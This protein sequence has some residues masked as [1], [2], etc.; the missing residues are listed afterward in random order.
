MTLQ[1]QTISARFAN[2]MLANVV[3]KPEFDSSWIIQA[4]LSPDLLRLE[5]TRITMERFAQ[6]YRLIAIKTDDETVGMFSRPLRNGTLKYLCM[7]MLDAPQLRVALNRFR[8]FF[9]LVN[10][11]VQFEITPA[12]EGLVRIALHE[13][14]NLGPTRVLALELMLMLMQGVTSW[15]IAR[16]IPFVRIGFTFPRPAHAAEYEHLYPGPVHFNEAVTALYMDPVYLDEPIRQDQA[17]LGVFI[18]NAPMDW[19][20]F[21][22]TDRPHT[23]RVRNFLKDRLDQ[24]LTV[25]DVAHALHTSPRTLARWLAAEGTTFQRTK[26]KLRRDLA[27]ELLNKTSQPVAL[28]GSNLGFDDPAAFNRAFRQWTG[29]APGAYRKRPAPAPSFRPAD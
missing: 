23:H 15:L 11:D 17:S 2:A 27:I 4:G 3:D 16:K 5:G 13:K 24:S 19:F 9:R 21:S 28:I 6:L 10:D 7:I 22:D 29:S 1:A 8:N 12:S 14:T 18:R 26:D 25:D 20:Y